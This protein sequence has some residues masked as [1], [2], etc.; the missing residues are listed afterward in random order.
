[1]SDS[2]IRIGGRKTLLDYLFF[3]RPVLMP[4]VWTIALLGVATAPD[5]SHPWWEWAAF[6]VQLWCLF[7]AVYTLNQICDVE[8]DRINRK[9]FFL[10]ESLI[11]IRAAWSFTV[12]LNLVALVLGL[13]FTGIYVALTAGIMLL[14]VAYSAGRHPWKNHP[15]LGFLANTVA[16]GMI[17]YVMGI[18]FAGVYSAEAWVPAF[19]YACAVGA[20]YLAT[21]VAD[22]PGDQQS[23]KRTIGVWA[24][25]RITML[26][27]AV[28]VGVA[29]ILAMWQ[30]QV[31]LALASLVSLPVFAWGAQSDS[32]RRAP[33]V[34]ITG[35]ATLTLGASVYFPVYLGLMIIG[36]FLARAFFRWR[37]GM[38]YPNFG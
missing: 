9:L 26:L 37:F 2:P 5:H 30:D 18:T 35:V 10:P 29:V 8:S 4:P 1:M 21:T 24:G 34:A 28:L 7:G 14:G 13:L 16:H 25:G 6:V 20:V 11:S 17:V 32:L 36:F 33:R 12:A 15:L 3:T 31:V 27:A 23:G 38:A 19:A 22:I